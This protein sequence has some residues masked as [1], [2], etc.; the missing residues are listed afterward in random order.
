MS[1]DFLL[2][3]IFEQLNTDYLP[4][5]FIVTAAML[6]FILIKAFA[7][8]D[9]YSMVALIRIPICLTLAVWIASHWC[10]FDAT[11]DVRF[12]A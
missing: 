8:L 4:H 7:I 12:G 9:G 1:P 10:N 2:G 11:P 6:S 3:A 5:R